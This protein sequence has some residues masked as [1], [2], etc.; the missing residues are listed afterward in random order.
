MINVYFG[1]PGGPD[2]RSGRPDLHSSLQVTD[3]AFDGGV[4]LMIIYPLAIAAAMFDS[5]MR[6]GR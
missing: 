2:P 3:W 1:D 6:V 5:L 4:P